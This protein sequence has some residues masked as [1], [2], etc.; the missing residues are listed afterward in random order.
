MTMLNQ[1]GET[2]RRYYSDTDSLCYEIK[3]DD[4]YEDI[5]DDAPEWFD[6]SNY[7]EDHPYLV[8][9]IKSKLYL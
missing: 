7:E 3:T 9:R 1:S 4:I 2:K 8:R 6:T 5:K